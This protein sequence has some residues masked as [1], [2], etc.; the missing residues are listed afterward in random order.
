MI[1][2]ETAFSPIAQKKLREKK[3]NK[4]EPIFWRLSKKDQPI[5]ESNWADQEE[6]IKAIVGVDAAGNVA[7]VDKK[8]MIAYGR[9]IQDNLVHPCYLTGI[10]DF[11][12]EE[13][14]VFGHMSAKEHFESRKKRASYLDTFRL[15]EVIVDLDKW[16]EIGAKL[17]RM[18]DGKTFELCLSELE[19]TD[20]LSPNY[21]L[22]D[23]Y[24]VW[25]CNYR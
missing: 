17:K 15:I 7:D 19:S 18:E 4:G 13:S 3:F 11:S 9:F 23:D 25:F 12:W 22:L 6:R 8:T 5:I 10:E 16:N 2:K 24:S 21:Q 1:K 14:F 20:Y